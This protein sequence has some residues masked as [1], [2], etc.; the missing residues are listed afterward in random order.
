LIQRRIIERQSHIDLNKP[1]WTAPI[2]SA[3]DAG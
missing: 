3:T 2:Y 1:G